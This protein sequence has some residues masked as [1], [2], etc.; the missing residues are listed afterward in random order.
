MILVT[1]G[2]GTLG[3][4]I[5]NRLVQHG[6]RVRVFA[7][8]GD[9]LSSIRLSLPNIEICRGDIGDETAL[10]VALDGVTVVIHAAGIAIPLNRY[11]D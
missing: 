3:H 8:H 9:S 11:A 10:A 1:G 5:V 6:H 2:T 7:E 4:H